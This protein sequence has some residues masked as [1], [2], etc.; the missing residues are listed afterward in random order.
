MLLYS[1]QTF[2]NHYCSHL[3]ETQ[4]G[5]ATWPWPHS[6]EVLEPEVNPTIFTALWGL[7]CG[8]SMWRWKGSWDQE[9]ASPCESQEWRWGWAAGLKKARS[10][11]P[12]EGEV[13]TWKKLRDCWD[14]P[15]PRRCPGSPLPPR[16]C[17]LLSPCLISNQSQGLPRPRL[18]VEA[19]GWLIPTEKC[20]RSFP[21]HQW[22]TK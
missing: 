15:I 16:G 13:T 14:T 5:R 22:F 21:E 4:R 2:A 1:E 18:P 9:E 20:S 19:Y 11:G 10:W 8:R 7:T 3:T 12:K 17:I 6:Q